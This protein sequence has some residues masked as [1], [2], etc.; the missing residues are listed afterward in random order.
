[1]T[2][3]KAKKTFDK[4]KIVRLNTSEVF[5]KAK[6]A[7]RQMFLVFRRMFLHGKRCFSILK[8]SSESVQRTFLTLFA[9]QT[10]KF[11]PWIRFFMTKKYLTVL[12][13]R[14]PRLNYIPEFGIRNDMNTRKSDVRCP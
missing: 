13:Q 8:T 9:K 5:D 10:Y 4:A 3:F 6:M 12:K 11:T 2:G 1:M 7:V 14:K